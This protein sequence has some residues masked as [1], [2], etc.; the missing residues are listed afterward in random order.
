MSRKEREKGKRGEREV[1]TILRSHGFPG[2]RTSQYA[3]H[4]EDSSDVVGLDGFH[5]EVK[6]Q[7]KTRIFEW[8]EQAK[9]DAEEKNIPMVVFRRSGENWFALLDF[10][11]LLDVLSLLERLVKGH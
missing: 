7:E 3:G 9:R 5:L 4:T 6:R 2:R 1:A 11:D 10:E 8:Y